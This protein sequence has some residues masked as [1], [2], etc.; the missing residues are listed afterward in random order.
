MN[1]FWY[2]HLFFHYYI[3]FLLL[4]FRRKPNN[5]FLA[6]IIFERLR[7]IRFLLLLADQWSLVWYENR[8]FGI[9]V[10]FL[11]YFLQILRRFFHFLNYFW[12]NLF[13]YLIIFL[14]YLNTIN[15]FGL[16][17]FRRKSNN[18]LLT[19]IIFER[20]RIIRF[21]LL[22]ADQWSFF[23]Y[24]N[25]ILCILVGLLLFLIIHILFFIYFFQILWRFFALLHY[26]SGCLSYNLIRF[27]DCTRTIEFICVFYIT[28]L[29]IIVSRW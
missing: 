17:F 7:N 20:L 15:D 18:V 29:N 24:K 1:I 22:L 9:H 6:R 4:F 8:I 23:W 10:L 11:I 13:L 25:R 2:I 21:L 28:S 5:V 19:G 16:L 27:V 12:G 3:N 14:D 26:L